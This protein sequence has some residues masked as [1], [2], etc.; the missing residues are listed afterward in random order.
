MLRFFNDQ[1][2]ERLSVLNVLSATVGGK[3]GLHSTFNV[4]LENGKGHDVTKQKDDAELWSRRIKSLRFY[5]EHQDWPED[6]NPQNDPCL[7][8]LQRSNY[9]WWGKSKNSVS[10][11]IKAVANQLG[12]VQKLWKTA[13][14]DLYQTHYCFAD[15]RWRLTTTINS[16]VGDGNTLCWTYLD[17]LGPLSDPVSHPTEIRTIATDLS[18]LKAP[19]ND[20]SSASGEHG[21]SLIVV[22]A[23]EHL[24]LHEIQR[25][26]EKDSEDLEKLYKS[27][28]GIPFCGHRGKWH[29]EVFVAVDSLF[30]V[31]LHKHIPI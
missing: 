27:M 10:R 1:L 6:L 14:A 23:S 20:P 31:K 25:A 7:A 24:A 29:P 4:M 30:Q 9:H 8:I 2:A 28:I 17:G 15:L 22:S 19:A 18:Q 26:A 11:D 13:R 5:N 21:S 16:V 12:Q 3:K